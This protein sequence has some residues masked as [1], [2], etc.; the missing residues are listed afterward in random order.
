[1]KDQ[2]YVDD[3][4]VEELERVLLIKRREARLDRLRKTRHPRELQGRDPLEPVPPTSV[5]YDLNR[6]SFEGI[7]VFD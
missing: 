6:H 2:R 5:A 7:G 1:M 4:E 3:L